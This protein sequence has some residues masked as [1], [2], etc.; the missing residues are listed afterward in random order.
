MIPVAPNTFFPSPWYD[1]LMTHESGV[2]NIGYK[3]RQFILQNIF[4]RLL[5]NLEQHK[6]TVLIVPDA[7]EQKILDHWLNEVG[8]RHLA[9]IHDPSRP[10][11]NSE[12]DGLR[13]GEAASNKG[14][15][16]EAG[17]DYQRAEQKMAAF[18]HRVFAEEVWE[19]MTWRQVL[20]TYLDAGSDRKDS[21]LHAEA[22]TGRLRFTSEEY[23]ELSDSISEALYLYK[24]DFE[25]IERQEG[26]HIVHA[27]KHII[28]NLDHITDQ[29]FRCREQA[30]NLRDRYYGLLHRLEEEYLR[31]THAIADE[32]DGRI[33]KLQYRLK[34]MK[35]PGEKGWLGSWFRKADSTAE[36]VLTEINFISGGL[37]SKGILREQRS[38][39]DHQSPEALLEAWR[40]DIIKWI[41]TR[42]EAMDAWIRSVNRLNHAEPTLPLLENEAHSLISRINALKVHGQPYEMNTLSFRKQMEYISK[43][44]YE[45]EII[46]ESLGRNVHYYQWMAWL[47]ELDDKKRNI[48]HLLRRFD[49]SEWLELFESWYHMEMLRRHLGPYEVWDGQVIDHTGILFGKSRKERLIEAGRFF[50]RKAKSLEDDVKTKF[51]D[52]YQLM[53][54]KNKPSAPVVFS[55]ALE[56]APSYMAHCFP[57]L[58]LNHD[59]IEKMAPGYYYEMISLTPMEMNLEIMQAFS[60]I[61]SLYGDQNPGLPDM[62]HYSLPRIDRTLQTMSISERL[63]ASR[64]LAERLVC[65]RAEPVILQL[66]RATIVSFSSQTV[67][68]EIIR[69]FYKSGIKRMY[70]ESSAEETL[71]TCLVNEDSAVFV[72]TEN[73]LLNPAGN[74][75]HFFSQ[76][77]A[78]HLL[79]NAGCKVINLNVA[80]LLNQKQKYIESAMS[81]VSEAA[82]RPE[83]H[84]SQLQLEFE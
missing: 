33:E 53:V 49:P 81:P 11:T 14:T 83:D 42:T 37:V 21:V 6:P 25:W 24:R 60:S 68:D 30:S 43:L 58:I 13:Q 55:R 18:Y 65:F 78:I 31:E 45:M 7:G 77:E 15:Y 44:A 39:T 47:D 19:G 16:T 1:K 48:I 5:R 3:D 50:S 23:K 8:I 66:R 29:V 62:V 38:K 34:L 28:A 54:K 73:G 32:W 40:Q 12:M 72:V 64:S 74:P 26:K 51:P 63:S 57:V 17:F 80:K 10:L 35:A 2:L 22:E 75:E 41:E 4:I 20:D 9:I 59:N 36:E 76:R 56:K 69:L 46:L 70:P 84:K 61:I 82:G 79:E 67:N 71:L 52:L 27:G